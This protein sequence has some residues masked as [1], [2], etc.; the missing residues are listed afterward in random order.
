MIADVM[1]YKQPL[2]RSWET[3]RGHTD[4]Y[5]D[6]HRVVMITGDDRVAELIEVIAKGFP[7]PHAGDTKPPFDCLVTTMAGG[8]K[9]YNAWVKL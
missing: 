5:E 2:A 6:R 7:E 3:D 4:T 9:E 1:E 8:S